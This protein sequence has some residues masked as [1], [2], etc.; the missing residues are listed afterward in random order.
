MEP[1]H[2]L[3]RA[4]TE[5]KAA[6]A[7]QGLSL[8]GSGARPVRASAMPIADGPRCLAHSHEHEYDRASRSRRAA[9]AALTEVLRLSRVHLGTR[10]Q[11]R[12]GAS[13]K[14]EMPNVLK[15][16]TIPRFFGATY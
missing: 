4:V 2:E 8:T 5:G 15:G 3:A 10:A 14:W 16:D 11:G 13:P 6:A 9:P 12:H 7:A 1:N